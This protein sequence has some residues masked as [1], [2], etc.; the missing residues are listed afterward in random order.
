MLNKWLTLCTTIGLLKDHKVKPMQDVGA[1]EAI[2][3]NQ[4]TFIWEE[5]KLS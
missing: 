4:H 5:V 3:L 1:S 2:D